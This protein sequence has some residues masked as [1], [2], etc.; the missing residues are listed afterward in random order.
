MIKIEKINEVYL[1]V[2]A[3]S[4]ILM[5]LCDFFTFEVPNARFTKLYKERLWDGKYRLFDIHRK[6]L[7]L[8]LYE[9][10]IKF[11]N[12]SNYEYEF[13]SNEYYGKPF[14]EENIILDDLLNFIE[15]LN[16]HSN[17]KKLEIRDYQITAIYDILTKKRQ[18][19]L[20]PTSSGKSLIIYV[21]LRWLLDNDK[22]K[23][24]LIVPTVGLVNQMFND[25]SDYSSNNGFDVEKYCHKIFAGED[26]VT[27]KNISI[28][29]WQSIYKL[30]STYFNS[31]DGIICDEAHGFQSKE[32]IKLMSNTTDVS[33]KIGVTGTIKQTKTHSL[34]LQG[35]FGP[36][37]KVITTKELI[38]NKQSSDIKINVLLL[39]YSDETVKSTKKYQYIDEVEFI[40]S[41]FARNKFIRN[42]AIKCD[43]NTLVLFNHVETHGKIIYDLIKEKTDKK[44]FFIHGGINATE[45]EEIRNTIT[46][47][48][49]CIAVAS[50]GTFSTGINIPS[51]ENIIFAALNKSEIKVLQS[52]GRGLRLYNGKEKC[53]LYDLVDDLSY[54]KHHN[55]LLKHGVERIKIYNSEQFKYTTIEV[56]LE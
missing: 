47:E 5:E 22:S 20:S 55:Y 45:R 2:N 21:V 38:N 52:I 3:S 19:I 42:L 32:L 36:I 46:S 23:L 16:I 34:V 6:T 10:L 30:Q 49:N 43:G 27:K 18:L 13:I 11:L 9:Q 50:V 33:Y 31:F 53:N 12:D 28:S 17:N 56:P 37:N 54:K 44:V 4:D 1:R 39:K 40:K 14:I 48:K 41:H 35:L 26:K 29:T 15:K 51:L 8:G 24:L 7:F 25:F